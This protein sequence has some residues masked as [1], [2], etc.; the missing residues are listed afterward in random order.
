MFLKICY[1]K[2]NEC[3]RERIRLVYDSYYETFYIYIFQASTCHTHFFQ[4]TLISWKSTFE[5]LCCYSNVV[6]HVTRFHSIH[7]AAATRQQGLL[8]KCFERL[9]KDITLMVC[10]ISLHTPVNLV[11]HTQSS[12]CSH[13]NKM[14]L[15][16][17]LVLN[18]GWDQ[19]FLI[20]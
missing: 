12:C 3:A 4:N 15:S 18:R 10:R 1:L 13:L 17:L 9:K 16:S 11:C 8:I 20:I 19:E 2:R 6:W 7:E 14:T 5:C